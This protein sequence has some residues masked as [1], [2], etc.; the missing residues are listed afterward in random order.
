[1]QLTTSKPS[2]LLCICSP[3]NPSL[4]SRLKPYL[5]ID[6]SQP[7]PE[8]LIID[9]ESSIAIDQIRT[10]KTF[11]QTTPITQPHKLV[12]IHQIDKATNQAQ[13][14]LL[15]TLE[16]PPIYAQIV[17]TTNNPHLVLSTIKSRC[18]IIS[19]LD[20]NETSG[21]STEDLLLS[22]LKTLSTGQRMALTD[23][24]TKDRNQ[25][26]SFTSETIKH[27]RHQLKAQPNKNNLYN[28]TLAL[29]THKLLKQSINPKLAI[30]QFLI[31]FK[32]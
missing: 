26:L 6:P 17:L 19:L 20:S 2:S 25:A 10:I 7:S 32:T 11:F 21:P 13:N 12:F 24:L 9:E 28:L 4:Y 15:K 16:E 27:L 22:Q 23:K 29:Y 1:M 5:Y 3:H 14:A 30:D 18:Q 31:Y 8:V